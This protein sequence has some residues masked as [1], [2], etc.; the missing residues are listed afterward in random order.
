MAVLRITVVSLM[1]VAFL[2]QDVAVLAEN[3]E[4][5]ASTAAKKENKKKKLSV[6]PPIR[7]DKRSFSRKV[8]DYRSLK[9]INIV[10][11]RRDYSCG[12][13]ALAT[14]GKFY[15]GDNVD[16]EFF[17]TILDLI[18]TVEE[19][20]ERV[21]NG[22]AMADLRKAA[23]KAGYQAVV[24]K[25]TFEKLG[26]SKVPLLV[27][28]TV[29]EFDHFVVYRGTDGRYVYLADPIRGNLRVPSAVFVKQW[30]KNAVLAIA[31]PGHK[32]KDISP[33]SLRGEELFLGKINEQIARTAAERPITRLP[34]P[35]YYYGF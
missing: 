19:A 12:A 18:L 21:E 29:D 5:P 28:I 15:W 20:K 35:R 2:C 10:M 11:Q 17:L 31:K 22:L 33:L 6:G 26:D 25:L 9:R 7:D 32:V 13:A 8:R 27:G 34:K 1:L 24:G 3:S 23:V 30:Q 4:R 14:I 16:E